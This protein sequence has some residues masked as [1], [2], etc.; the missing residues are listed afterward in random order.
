MYALSRRKFIKTCA[1]G[2]SAVSIAGLLPADARSL[3]GEP[4]GQLFD[5]RITPR[6]WTEF[7][8]HGFPRP[9]SGAK[10]L[11][12]D[13][14]CCGVPV[15]GISTGCLDVDAR[16]VYGFSSI[17]N[18]WSKCPTRENWRM[19]RKPQ[20]MEPILGL[21][22]GG[23][24][25]V[26]AMPEIVQGGSVPVCQDPFF[27]KV[28][29]KADHREI[30]RLQGVRA[31]SE[32]HY[33]GHYPAVDMEYVNDSP[34]AVALRA[35]S[36]FIPG[37]TLA[38]N[39]PL[40]IFEVHVK[41]SASTTQPVTLAFNFP[42][43]DR[44]EAGSDHFTRR[45]IAEDVRGTYVVSDGGV[46]YLAG[47][48]GEKSI[49]TGAALGA[50]SWKDIGHSLPAGGGEAR[51]SAAGTSLAVDFEL[52]RGEAR[53]IR[54]LLAW[55]AP[56]WKGAE[57]DRL[58]LLQT[59][60]AGGAQTEWKGSQ[61]S[62]E[63]YYTLKYADRYR[64][65]LEVAR[66]AALNHA[67]LLQRVQSWQ[68]A[69]FADK[70]LPVWL[71]DSLVN[72]FCLLAEDAL[73]VLPRPP[74]DEWAISDGAFGLIES[75]RGDPDLAC[76]PCDWYGNL[77]VV[78]FFPSLAM[79]NIRSY[80]RYQRDDGIVPF[81]LGVL[82]DLPDFAT[83]SYEW[84][85]SLNGTCYVDMVDRVWLRSGD[86]DV[87]KEFY[88]SV[89][90]CNTATMHLRS[91]PE[92]PISMPEGNKG[93]EWFEHGEWAGM[94]AH[95]GGLHLAQLRMVRRMAEHV[96][97]HAYVKQCDAWLADGTKAMEQELWNGTYYLNFYEKESGKR[98][99][100]VMAYQLDGEWASRYHGA[101]HVFQPDRIDTTLATIRRINV[102]LTPK[103][104]AANFARP[105]G[106]PLEPK[107]KIAAYGPLAMFPA[108]V[109]VLAMT[110]IYSGQKDFGLDLA[111]RHWETIVC[112]HGHGWDMPNIVRGDT[113]ERVYGTDY[114]QSMMLW[115]LPAALAGEDIAASRS[116]NSLVSRVIEAGRDPGMKITT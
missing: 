81:W 73:W 83:P 52:G 107:S 61:W 32:I 13:P 72:N 38:S 114:Y 110:Y 18:P 99:D 5:P 92:G 20:S 108:E 82:G 1:Q 47:A 37:D 95:L 8:A 97:D 71:R 100:D 106:R 85:I 15:G 4:Q 103:V 78:Y 86:D 12:S 58:A 16:G 62:S 91:G 94:C 46:S 44:Q 36:P 66:E 42:G 76:I 19:P 70:S 112:Q 43:P 79:S 41:N 113:G 3:D 101:G 34:I 60:H 74:L 104:G 67:A 48:L 25:W 11:G 28:A 45:D 9:V 54:F 29:E 105:D 26:L 89:K 31:A 23:Q 80:K 56:T 50:D 51:S 75:P 64:D 90:R 14:P 93:M 17:F 10:F 21:A 59:H 102:A 35:W 24:V 7:S 68:D 39:T 109:L 98:S 111:R 63:N 33:W 88:D 55:Y 116:G 84:Q 40:A 6:R 96:N 30:P 27:G 2:I 115:A 57:R 65:A 87:L 69:I 22:V 49:R 77:P 53:V